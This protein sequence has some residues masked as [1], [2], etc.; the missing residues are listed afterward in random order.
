MAGPRP[1]APHRVDEGRRAAGRLAL[2]GLAALLL[3]GCSP[4]SGDSGD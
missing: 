3:G 2:G 1:R 4:G